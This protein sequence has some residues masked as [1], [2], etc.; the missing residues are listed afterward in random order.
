MGMDIERSS[1]FIDCVPMMFSVCPGFFT[2][3]FCLL[4]HFLAHPVDFFTYRSGCN[5]VLTA[6]IK[7]YAVFLGLAKCGW[8]EPWE[9]A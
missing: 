8:S 2:I 5:D 9:G 3:F 6:R 1:L 7:K 4:E